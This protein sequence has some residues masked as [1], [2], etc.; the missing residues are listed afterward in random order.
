[1]KHKIGVLLLIATVCAT[2]SAQQKGEK[3]EAPSTPGKVQP[4]NASHNVVIELDEA[5]KA[6]LIA[7]K[8]LLGDPSS[9][10]GQ[11]GIAAPKFVFKD[12][13]FYLTVFGDGVLVPMV[14]GGASGCFSFDL[15]NRI[16]DLKKL[17]ET[18]PPRQQQNK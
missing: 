18:F 8:S 3:G 7:N 17:I 5:I 15:A 1:M 4:A 12:G 9:V 10:Q 6:Y 2:A 13:A 14:G 16:E 11:Q